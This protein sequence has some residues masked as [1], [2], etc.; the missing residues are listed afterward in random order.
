MK[1]TILF[2]LLLLSCATKPSENQTE[3]NQ[4]ETQRVIKPEFQALIDSANLDGAILI[5]DEESKT[6]FSNDF[7]WSERGQLPASTFKIPNGII[8]LETGVVENDSVLFAWNGEERAFK[9]WEQDLIFRDAFQVSCLPCFQEIARNIGVERMKAYLEKLDYGIIKFDSLT[10]DN[11]WV[12]GESRINQ[13]EQIDFLRRFY[14]SELPISERTETLMKSIMVI[15]KNENY[16]ISGKTGWSF[17]EENN[18]G[19][20]VGYMESE[21]KV[22][23]FATNLEPKDPSKI[24]EF[25]A[26]RKDLT[27]E[28]FRLR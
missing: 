9:V 17:S 23:F 16:R 4:E 5:F 11:F 27:Y 24:D 12:Q 15:E 22:L 8:A 14:H 20:F 26:A 7:G 1:P 21:G 28:A 3:A 18:N 13:F 10:I 19:W 2:A 6:Y 25:V